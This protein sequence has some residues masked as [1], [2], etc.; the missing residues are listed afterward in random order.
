MHELRCI[1][2]KLI[3]LIGHL[4]LFHHSDFW[5]GLKKLHQLD[6]KIYFSLRFVI[7]AP[8]L[9]NL[10][11][12]KWMTK[13]AWFRATFNSFQTER[14]NDTNTSCF[15]V[16]LISPS[17]AKSHF[18]CIEKKARIPLSWA[19]ILLSAV[20]IYYKNNMVFKLSL[21]TKITVPNK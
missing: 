19:E 10:F 13:T 15:Q 9:S 18:V 3:P 5:S 14:N 16:I 12:F 6:F 17:E 11:C 8:Q 20:D 21:I 4:L 1:F 7:F 2:K